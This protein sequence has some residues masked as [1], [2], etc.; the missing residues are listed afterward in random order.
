MDTSD[1]RRFRTGVRAGVRS[2]RT[3]PVLFFVAVT[4][5]TAGL[6]LFGA[7]LLLVVNMRSTAQRLGDGFSVIAYAAPGAQ[8]EQAQVEELSRQLKRVGGVERV[9]YVSREEALDR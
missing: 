1:W 6:T 2:V 4:V 3:E 9:S 8:L 7:F 5:M